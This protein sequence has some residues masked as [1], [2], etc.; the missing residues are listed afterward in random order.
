MIVLTI[1]RERDREREKTFQDYPSK[2][3]RGSLKWMLYKPNDHYIDPVLISIS[4]PLVQKA[5]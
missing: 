5:D 4:L 1:F 2:A 3:L